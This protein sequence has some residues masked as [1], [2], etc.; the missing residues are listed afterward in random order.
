MTAA[1]RAVGDELLIYADGCCTRCVVRDQV[2]DLLSSDGEN[3]MPQLS[4]LADALIC[5]K[6]PRS[7]IKWI[8]SSASAQ[9]MAE[10][11]AI[12][13]EI[14]HELLDGLP[15]TT[16]TR[17]VR[18]TL[19][20]TRV[21]PPR[22]EGLARLELWIEETLDAVSPSQ[23]RFVR[24]FAEWLVL[25]DARQR[26]ARDRFTTGTAE[27][28]RRDIRAAIEL[29]DWLDR[30]TIDLADL[31]QAQFELWLLAVKPTRRRGIGRFIRWTNAR[32]VTRGLE[33]PSPKHGLA[34]RFMDEDQ[35]Q[36]QLRRCLTDTSL[37]LELRIVGAL[38]RLY[39]LPLTRIVQLTTDRF[40]QSESGSYLV[41]A[42]YPVL[43]SPS[44]AR[45]IEQQIAGGRTPSMLPTPIPSEGSGVLLMPGRPAHRPRNP[46]GLAQQ[47]SDHGLPTI[48]AR[49][50]A[51]IGMASELPPVIISDL[52]GIHRNTANNWA[53]LAQDGW[54]D[55]LAACR[56]SE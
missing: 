21:L 52:F 46:D 50:T 37:P 32:H 31:D 53:A 2:S 56:L 15:Q 51:M 34:E 4:P 24:P 43:L 47:L 41:I 6:Y 30:N 39:A 5:A 7:V 17:S 28:G 9:L 55:Y 25:R 10:L 44:L 42:R 29:M 35:H 14:T 22:H 16:H 26:A 12:R 45:L 49:H 3:V 23:R 54:A 38:I 19:V 8:R 1:F 20:A 13:T 33:A 11:A 18:E 48:A 27:G 36:E 40:V